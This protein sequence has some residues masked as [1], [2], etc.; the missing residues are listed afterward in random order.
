MNT[1]STTSATPTPTLAVAVESAKAYCGAAHGQSW[2]L[3]AA[4]PVP[5]W[6]ELDAAGG[7][8]PYRLVHDPRRAHPARDHEGNYLYMP[9][10]YGSA[11]SATGPL[12]VAR[13]ASLPLF[14]ATSGQR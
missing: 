11:A 13:P 4:A 3:D 7:V 8:H 12:A 2:I 9:A 10:A 6:V 5:E 1:P 14:P